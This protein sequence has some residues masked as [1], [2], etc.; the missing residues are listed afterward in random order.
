LKFQ[1]FREKIESAQ[2]AWRHVISTAM[3]NGIGIPAFST[4]LHYFYHDL[5]FILMA[6][7]G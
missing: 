1:Y 4:A 2:D 7:I 6:K 5:Y 3:L